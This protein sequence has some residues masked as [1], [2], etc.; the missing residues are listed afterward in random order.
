MFYTNCGQKFLL[1]GLL[2]VIMACGKCGCGKKAK[3]LC[4]VSLGLAIGLTS[5][6][7]IFLWSAW[8][9]MHG[10]PPEMANMPGPTWGDA[11]MHA[12]MALIK[13]FVFGAVVGIIYDFCICCCKWKCCKS[14]GTCNCS[15]CNNPNDNNINNMSR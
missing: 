5:A 11:G 7:A 14:N 4:P 10:M 8:I 12:L 1:D 13:G 9:I 3:G 2:E 6:L 15:C